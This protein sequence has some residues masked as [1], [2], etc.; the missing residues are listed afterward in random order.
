MTTEVDDFLKHYGVL[1]MKW[2]KRK[3]GD[4]AG[5]SS[6]PRKPRTADI[7]A[8]R[9]RQDVRAREFEE[10]SAEYYTSRSAKGEKFAERKMRNLEWDLFNNP[11]AAVANRMTAGEKW[12]TGFF[13]A[14]PVLLTAL[15]IR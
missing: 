3:S 10:A 7:K 2:G 5:E 8:A 13:V 14:A 12:T 4:S 6:K 15:T 11:D 1:G 9:K